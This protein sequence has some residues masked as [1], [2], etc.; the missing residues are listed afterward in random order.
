[1]SYPL[2]LTSDK[3]EFINFLSDNI[4]IKKDSDIALTKAIL[5]IP[6]VAIEEY[7]I[8]LVIG[9]DQGIDALKLVVDGIDSN[10]SWQDIFDAY[11][12]LNTASGIDNNLNID[13]FYSGSYNLPLNNFINF[14]NGVGDIKTKPNI[15]NIICLAFDTK[16]SFYDIEASPK[17][18]PTTISNIN[19]N[20]DENL[21]FNGAAYVSCPTQNISMEIGIKASY[22][23]NKSDL[24]TTRIAM[25]TANAFAWTNIAGYTVDNTGVEGATITSN[26]GVDKDLD[27][28]ASCNVSTANIDPN[29]GHFSF[30][31]SQ[32][33]VTPVGSHNHI[34]IVGLTEG[35]GTGVN[36]VPSDGFDVS[37][38]VCGIKFSHNLAGGL[39]LN[40]IDGDGQLEPLTEFNTFD[41]NDYFFIRIAR[42][43]DAGTR[44][45]YNFSVWESGA[46]LWDD[47]CVLLYQSPILLSSPLDYYMT[48]SSNVTGMGI[49]D[50][51]FIKMTA[52]SN[53]QLDSNFPNPIGETIMYEFDTIFLEAALGDLGYANGIK[54]FFQQ[55]GIQYLTEN[56]NPCN[57]SLGN[58][59]VYDYVLPRNVNE[60][61][62]KFFIGENKITDMFTDGLVNATPVLNYN[63][64]NLVTEI[65][66]MLDFTIKDLNN[67]TY[68]ASNVGG[69]G[70]IEN[71]N[72][73]TRVVG[74]ILVPQ[75]YITKT[76]SFD[77]NI[78]YEPY[79]LIYRKLYN[80]NNIPVNQFNCKLGYKDFF[81]NQEKII[82]SMNGVSKYEVHI[83]ECGGKMEEY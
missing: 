35:L 30:K 47:N 66:R 12:I 71:S 50:C 45:Q 67:T 38:Y 76:N 15:C 1:M 6:V 57:S 68:Q 22:N 46:D 21:T 2:I 62:I 59:Y 81:N 83:K 14:I 39:I 75:E 24:Q 36:V 43:T 80:R 63:V 27:N 49:D 73:I 5:S 48:T 52:D 26:G 25:N 79:N 74:T 33:G 78:S 9:P 56:A 72:A 70:N 10:I 77:M 42:A 28:V 54:V 60:S 16:F 82:K 7:T 32:M 31:V 4:D 64:N 19:E 34:M 23:P 18:T 55:I 40:I 44:R 20:G 69:T 8:P 58:G 41:L 51:K 11:L 37:S 29:G 61:R 3:A 13:D 17:L 65:P 53:D